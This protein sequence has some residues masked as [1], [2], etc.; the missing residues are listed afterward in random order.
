MKQV[1]KAPKSELQIK[2]S[3]A[4][5]DFLRFYDAKYRYQVLYGGSGSGKSYHIALK[6]LHRI[7]SEKP[8]RILVVRKVASTLR[9]SV[10]Q[11]LKQIVYDW[12][13]DDEFQINNSDMRIIHL[14]SK[15]EIIFTGVDDPEKLKSITG[16]TSVWLE[17]AT[18]FTQEDWL[19]ITL[20][21]RGKYP[22]PVCFYIS[23]NPVSNQHW[24]FTYVNTLVNNKISLKTTYLDNAFLDD[25]YKR[26][27]RDLKN[28]D[29]LYYQ[30]Y[31]LGDWGEPSKGL[32]YKK[33]K[34]VQGIPNEL[35]QEPS[36]YGLDFAQSGTTA[37][38]EVKANENMLWAKEVFYEK[39]LSFDD[40]VKMLESKNISKN[41]EIY[42][43]YAYPRYIE[44]L[45]EL[46]YNSIFADK[47]VKEGI[48]M[49]TGYNMYLDEMSYNL[50][51]EIKRYKWKEKIINGGVIQLDEPLKMFDHLLD[52]LRYSIFTH[53]RDVPKPLQMQNTGINYSFGV[54]SGWSNNDTLY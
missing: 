4:F 27:M 30:I 8:H 25:E 12:G 9:Q 5:Y 37:M 36:I 13:V 34:I 2:Y 3:P 39:N 32:I 52:G 38:V 17:E 18:E 48:G 51:M 31:G 35:K 19:Q 1:K 21:V 44:R 26:R 16:I 7:R 6:I 33:W 41:I 47:S 40:V 43:D 53:F 49:L 45:Q 46:G 11:L 15:N 42:T 20:R 14:S 22:N 29:E 23:F 28:E 10:F 24:L 50:Q 54:Y